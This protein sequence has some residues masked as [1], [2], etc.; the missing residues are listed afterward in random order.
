MTEPE[1][2]YTYWRQVWRGTC[3]RAL[4]GEEWN[5]SLWVPKR[6]LRC[7]ANNRR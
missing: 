6:P 1:P 7:L 4:K 5:L 2:I 3:H